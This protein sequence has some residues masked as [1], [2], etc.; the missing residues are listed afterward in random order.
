MVEQPGRILTADSG[1]SLS[2]G[3]APAPPAVDV[4][5]K[6][7]TSQGS[8]PEW[9]AARRGRDASTGAGLVPGTAGACNPEWRGRRR[10]VDGPPR[11]RGDQGGVRSRSV[12]RRASPARPETQWGS[13]VEHEARSSAARGEDITVRCSAATGNPMMWPADIAQGGAGSSQ[14]S[15]SEGELDEQDASMNREAVRGMG[16][17][18]GCPVRQRQPSVNLSVTLSSPVLSK[19][20]SG[21]RD[22]STGVV[23][24]QGIGSGG[25]GQGSGS[26]PIGVTGERDVGVVQTLLAG[27]R[28][29]LTRCEAG[30][31]PVADASLVV[32]WAAAHIATGA[33]GG[34]SRAGR[35]S[36]YGWCR[37]GPYGSGGGGYNGGSW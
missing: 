25:L 9:R 21:C 14:D 15:L 16:D 4:R 32:A 12:A 10:Q 33:T 28:E 37:R 13:R 34:R 8:P 11:H 2:A 1:G 36:E 19:G 7:A 22:G 29:V 24:G 17:T 18:A 35:G 6:A 3:S 23:L 5:R 30:T 31:W 26:L 27:L 20:A